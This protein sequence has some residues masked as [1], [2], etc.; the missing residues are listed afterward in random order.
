MG[1]NNINCEHA[2]KITCEALNSA[3][4]KENGI[5]EI[6]NGVVDDCTLPEVRS[7]LSELITEKKRVIQRLM[8]RLDE[9]QEK[10]HIID[11][12]AESYNKEVE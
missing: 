2:C 3:L 1:N 4:K 12:I 10:S 8:Q 6:Y 9:L 5:L 7:L 11:D